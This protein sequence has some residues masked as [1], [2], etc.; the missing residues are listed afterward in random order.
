MPL[1]ITGG[2][3]KLPK[4]LTEEQMRAELRE[5]GLPEDIIKF[6]HPVDRMHVD[7]D[8]LEMDPY[9]DPEADDDEMIDVTPDKKAAERASKTSHPSA[10]HDRPRS[11]FA[12]HIPA[13]VL[14]GSIPCEHRAI[15]IGGDM[16]AGR[17]AGGC[18]FLLFL[19][20]MLRPAQTAPTTIRGLRFGACHGAFLQVARRTCRATRVMARR[21][22]SR[23]TAKPAGCRS[24]ALMG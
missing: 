21:H 16:T 7:P 23:A 9:P 18:S 14:L 13:P 15:A 3:N 6:M 8:E 22:R 20:F 11:R 17:Y 2:T 10:H 5:A 19:D 1:H 12:R 4:Y 24:F